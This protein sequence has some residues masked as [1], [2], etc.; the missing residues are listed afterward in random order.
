MLFDRD[1]K[2]TE[3]IEHLASNEEAVA[4]LYGAYANT[5]PV[6][7][8][9]WMSLAE[10]EIQ[11]ACWNLNATTG[12]SPISIDDTRFNVVAIS[13][14]MDYLDNE[15]ARLK[16]KSIPLIEAL[17]TTSYIE[18]SLIEAKFFEVYKT[19]SADLKEVLIKIRNE[20]TAHRNKARAE[21]ERYQKA[22]NP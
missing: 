6:L 21:L 12:T 9:F 4:K 17:S 7:R 5:F 13:S 22:G 2:Q 19:D 3:L 16:N 10:E 14:F 18:Q 11:H 20:T 15:L 8:E 1:K